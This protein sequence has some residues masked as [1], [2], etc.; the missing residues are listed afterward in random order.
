MS[1]EL[2]VLSTPEYVGQV[3]FGQA[4]HITCGTLAPGWQELSSTFP[5]ISPKNVVVPMCDW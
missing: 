2:G 5:I 1:G 3:G 4:G